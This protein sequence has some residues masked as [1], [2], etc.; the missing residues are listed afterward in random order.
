MQTLYKRFSVFAGFGI[1]VA[2]LLVNALVTRRQLGVQINSQKWVQH[3]R[4][5]LLEIERTE[6]LLKDAETGQRGYLYTGDAK[7]LAPYNTARTLVDEQ[8]ESLTRLTA[9]NPHQQAYLAELR[10]TAHDKLNELAETISLYQANKPDDAKKVVLSDRGLVLMQHIREVSDR[11]RQEETSLEAQRIAK[12]ERS[13]RLTVAC[14]YLASALAVMGLLLLAYYIVREMALREKYAHD[15]R[16]REEWFRVT[17]TSIG[18]AVIATD[19]KGKVTFMN[20]VAET[21]TGATAK[22]ALGR[23][24]NKVFPIFNEYT[25]EATANPVQKVMQLGRIVGLA[26]HTVL[27]H[28]QGQLVPIEDSAAPIRDDQNQLIG[29][30]LVFHDVTNERNSQELMRKTEK[31]AAA[32]RLSATV[33]HEI[34]NPLEAV[35]NL[36]YIARTTRGTPAEVVEQLAQAEQE[37]E[38]VAHITRQT[39]GF[40]RES[41]E[42]AMI[43]VG[44]LVESVLRL[45]SNKLKAKNI[46]IELKFEDCWPI[47]GI[48]GE[49]KQVISN[50]VSNAMDAVPANGKIVIRLQGAEDDNGKGVQLVIDDNG[51]G[52]PPELVSRIFEPFFT[53]KKDIGTG[54]GLWVTREIIERHGGGISVRANGDN[55]TRGAS[56]SI[57]L[58]CDPNR[59]VGPQMLPH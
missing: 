29:V 9:D 18:D 36:I 20:S 30:V 55:G 24:I 4:Q 54:L 35:G 14:I 7:Y 40:Y 22:S 16:A 23:D 5:I 15:I 19:E 59:E 25:G 2:L 32:A 38:R 8:I 49:L 1:L 37:L 6:S 51:P 46:Q 17:L 42:P 12:Y 10:A 33:A 53:T 39:L 47:L 3:T 50:L 58:P 56:F 41:N 27:K 44:A 57:Y 26:N 13:I 34:N 31:L 11:M 21:L 45:Y 52:I 48:E 43:Q 28:V